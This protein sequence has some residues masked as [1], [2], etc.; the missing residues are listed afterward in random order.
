MQNPYSS[1]QEQLRQVMAWYPNKRLYRRKSAKSGKDIISVYAPT[2]NFPVYSHEEWYA[3]NFES[4]FL[5]IDVNRSF[6][7]QFRELQRIAPVV[8]L[9]S[10]QQENAEFCQ[11]VENLKNCYLVFDAINCQ[12]VYYS[13]RIYHS[14][15]CVDVYWVMNSELLYDCV[16][17]FSCYN[18]KYSFHCQEAVDS[19]FLF[20]CRNVKNSF[21][22]SNL[23][24]KQYCVYN[25]QCT[26][27]EYETFVQ[28]THLSDYD[29][30]Q[31]FK[32]E[33]LQMMSRTP[34]PRSFLE[35]CEN[36]EGNYMKNS[37]NVVRG[38]E[39]FNVKDCE[40]IFQCSGG[41]NIVGSFMCNDR[42]EHCFQSVAT[43][44]SSSNVQNCA[45][46]WHSS[47]ME[48]STSVALEN[49]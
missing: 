9:L 44:I 46:V 33:F 7:E 6:F 5:D 43:G 17:M 10:T 24:N 21:M 4:R 38:F 40:N 32:S 28:N 26:K 3:E 39:S 30:I 34:I 23:R 20:N 12:D 47:N 1:P 16:Y 31:K 27:E 41:M 18:T 15:S 25:K 2:A 8:A 49:S 13:V 29:V 48:Y 36:V 45:F 19:H 35:N 42:V 11:D 14:R 22:C 37:Q